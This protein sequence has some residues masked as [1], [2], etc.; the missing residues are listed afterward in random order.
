MRE[1]AS[2]KGT[3]KAIAFVS[4]N[5]FAVLDDNKVIL[6]HQLVHYNILWCFFLKQNPIFKILGVS[7]RFGCVCLDFIEKYEERVKEELPGHARDFKDLCGWNRPSPTSRGGYDCSLPHQH[8][9]INRVLCCGGKQKRT[10]LKSSNCR[11][12]FQICLHGAHNRDLRPFECRGFRYMLR[13]RCM[14]KSESATIR[15]DIYVSIVVDL[16]G[17]HLKIGAIW[18][19]DF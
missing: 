17:E 19:G 9:E 3:C 12:H 8:E 2:M 6:A 4:R 14:D 11:L 16:H 18:A 7:T 15:T 13:Y 5:R 10:F 1:S